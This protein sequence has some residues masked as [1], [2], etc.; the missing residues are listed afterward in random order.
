MRG[1]IGQDRHRLADEMI[2]PAD[3]PGAQGP[4]AG[5]NP[6]KRGKCREDRRDDMRPIRETGDAGARDVVTGP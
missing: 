1:A 5:G 2:E 3:D 6:A 4:G